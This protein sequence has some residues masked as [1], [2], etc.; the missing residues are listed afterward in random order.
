MG[1]L[2]KEGIESQARYQSKQKSDI[3]EYQSEQRIYFKFVDGDLT[4]DVRGR[5]DGVF[6]QVELAGA[7]TVI[8]EIK[9][10]RTPPDEVVLSA[11]SVN[12]AQ[13]KLYAA[14][15]LIKSNLKEIGAQLTYLNPDTQVAHT[16]F[17]QYQAKELK[18]YLNETCATYA[19]WI[20]VV[21]QRLTLRNSEAAA[22][23]FPY[24][25]YNEDQQRL[26]RHGYMSLRDG[27]DLLFEAPT[28]SGKSMTA[29]FPAVKAMGEDKIDRVVF[30]T[31]RTTGQQA[32]NAA[33]LK[34][35]EQND[36]LVTVTVSAK[37]RVC[38]TPGAACRPEECTYAK[39]HYDRIREATSNLLL[40]RHVSRD[41]IDTIARNFKVCPFELS[42][43]A[44]EW[45]D[46][47]ICDYNY[48]FDPFVQLN[49][50]HSKLFDRVG[51]LV[52]EAHRVTDRVRESLSCTF[53][54]NMIE[55]ALSVDL[56]KRIQ[57]CL[58]RVLEALS[59]S[60][61]DQVS[62][63]GTAMVESV[64]YDITLSIKTLLDEL[65]KPE[66]RFDAE[67]ELRDLFYLFQQFQT[68]WAIRE[69]SPQK[70]A[71]QLE[72]NPTFRHVSLRCL[73]ADNWIASIFQ[74]YS[75]S[76]RFSGTLSPGVLYN[77]EH[78]LDGPC[79]TARISAD[80]DRLGV[81]VVPDLSTFYKDRERTAP[82]LAQL[83]EGVRG[84]ADGNWLVA[85]PS[86]TYLNQV[87][88]HMSE[89][90]SILVQERDL[91]LNER[92]EFINY[93]AVGRQMLAF[94]V[95]GGVFT[96]SVDFEHSAL[97]GVVVVSP[98]IPPQSPELERI[99]SLSDNGYEIAYRKPAM[100]RVIQ[101]AGRVLRNETD[102]G[103]VILIDSRF[104]RPDFSRY[105]PSHWIPRVIKAEDL[106]QE[107]ATFVQL[108]DQTKVRSDE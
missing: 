69:D 14:M 49:R 76:V 46:A 8:E 18:E 96:E 89:S 48:V 4:L 52:D 106:A 16:D 77:E 92:E 104:T 70:F 90:E 91:T 61:D 88:E 72:S 55:Q 11:R 37:E 47:I 27:T 65:E 29:S 3:A 33:F 51:L 21:L 25:K 63:R 56:P 38:L 34:L 5:V 80:P 79:L 32:A 2:A 67:G 103:L 17:N 40:R 58:S 81:L 50:I 85:F 20:S 42:L 39:G 28:G 107:V 13:M 22:Q 15:W 24:K 1:T 102:R 75:G 12:E 87:L 68:I 23:E 53:D 54:L 19:A 93:L 36:S 73:I 100:V 101:A 62:G 41:A 45:A 43:D 84:E 7:L 57:Q 98:G 71:W 31:A 9:T 105:F 26:A 66:N 94:V 10:T 60:L 95:M 83:L 99:R 64:G 59:S 78:G 74:N 97:E 44:A 86:F 108:D 35:R 30:C 6:E 82:E